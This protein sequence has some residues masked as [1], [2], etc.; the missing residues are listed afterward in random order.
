MVRKFADLRVW[1]EA[2]DF[3]DEV[4][5][6]TG[7]FP[8]SEVYGLTNQLRRAMISVPSNISEGCGKR[9]DKDFVRYLYNA[10]GSIK[11]VKCQLMIAIRREFLDREKG[12]EMVD[13]ADKLAGMLMKFIKYVSYEGGND[14]A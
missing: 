12:A 6:V 2:M 8:K 4:F 10:L 11:E 3:L 1:V 9:T 5:D 7:S 13:G 14:E